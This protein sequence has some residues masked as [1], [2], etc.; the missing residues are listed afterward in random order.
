MELSFA[1]ERIAKLY[2]QLCSC[3]TSSGRKYNG[4]QIIAIIKCNP[5]VKAY[6]EYK[7]SAAH[8]EDRFIKLATPTP[9]TDSL[10]IQRRVVY[11][12]TTQMRHPPD[13]CGVYFIG[14]VSC[15]PHTKEIQYWVKIGKSTTSIADRLSSYDTYSPSIYHIDYKITRASGMESAYHDLLR[16]ISYGRSER[17]REWFLVD[18]KTYLKMCELGFE[19]FNKI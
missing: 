1:L 18:E 9:C 10:F 12:A 2:S 19:Y 5:Q 4:E 7:S 8:W 15:N 3:S 13:C 16:L 14:N 11:D 17:N 6:W